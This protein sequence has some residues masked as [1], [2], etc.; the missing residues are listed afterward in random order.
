[1]L[2]M[3]MVVHQPPPYTVQK[4]SHTSTTYILKLH[5]TAYHVHSRL[6]PAARRTCSRTKCFAVTLAATTG[7]GSQASVLS[8][9]LL[10][11]MHAVCSSAAP[12]LRLTWQCVVTRLLTN[13]WQAAIPASSVLAPACLPAIAVCLCAQLALSCKLHAAT[14]CSALQKC[15]FTRSSDGTCLQ[16]K[17]QAA[18]AA[19]RNPQ[20]VRATSHGVLC[21]QTQS[22]TAQVEEGRLLFNWCAQLQRAVPYQLAGQ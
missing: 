5:S 16:A 8:T 1:M 19:T 15:C 2:L 22:T 11:P 6:L 3:L 12:L 7:L 4:Q 14:R 21:I 18:K 10:S 17:Q 20:N 13:S 9:R